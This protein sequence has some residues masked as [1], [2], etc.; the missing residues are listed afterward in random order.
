[1]PRP[2][3]DLLREFVTSRSES[4]FSALVGKYLGMTLGIARRRTGHQQLAEDI[5]QNVFAILA[6]KAPGLKAT[7]TLAG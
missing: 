4:A 7:P 1:M 3:T 5:A 6:R 2:D